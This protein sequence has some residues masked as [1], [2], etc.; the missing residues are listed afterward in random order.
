MTAV[1]TAPQT[2]VLAGSPPNNWG[3]SRPAPAYHRRDEAESMRA[4]SP[5]SSSIFVLSGGWL[6]G[7]G[8]LLDAS[9]YGTAGTGTSPAGGGGTMTTASTGGGGAG[10]TT[11]TGGGGTM[12][13]T[14]TGGTGGTTSTGG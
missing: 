11:S 12:T 8:C 6:L 10:G 1:E 3:V 5:L 7:T 4:R 14:M 9:P 13:T 2:N